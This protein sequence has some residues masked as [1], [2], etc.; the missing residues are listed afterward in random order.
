M[1]IQGD[2]YVAPEWKN[3]QPPAIN[4]QEL[5]D[6]SLS[7]ENGIRPVVQVTYNGGGGN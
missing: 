7:I 3:G 6:M 5:N 2:K 1:P 4:A